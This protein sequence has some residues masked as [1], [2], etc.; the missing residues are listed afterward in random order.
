MVQDAALSRRKHGFESRR[1]HQATFSGMPEKPE[2]LRKIYGYWRDGCLTFPVIPPIVPRLSQDEAWEKYV[3][4]RTVRGI[5]A[6]TKPGR[7]ADGDTRYLTVWPGGPKSWV[8]NLSRSGATQIFA[9]KAMVAK[10]T[11]H[12]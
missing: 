1:G 6:L 11:I 4:T 9:L 2:K 3:G 8:Q 12:A 5:S 10:R 7:Y